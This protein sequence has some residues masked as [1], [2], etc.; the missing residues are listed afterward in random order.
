MSAPTI[1]IIKLE[2]GVSLQS[3]G[4]SS[5]VPTLASLQAQR[6]TT[7]AFR[8]SEPPPCLTLHLRVW[9][10]ENSQTPCVCS[11][12]RFYMHKSQLFRQNMIGWYRHMCYQLLANLR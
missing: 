3:L 11:W 9:L 1:H 2:C 10:N 6:N 12:F 5:F 8:S 4:P 7:C